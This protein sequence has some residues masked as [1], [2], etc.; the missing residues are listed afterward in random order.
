MTDETRPD[1]EALRALSEAA[2]PGPW[3]VP[4][5]STVTVCHETAGW[6]AKC[7]VSPDAAFIA[8]A[9][10]YVRAPL[11]AALAPTAETC[12]AEGSEWFGPLLACPEPGRDGFWSYQECPR[13][14]TG[15]AA[16]RRLGLVHRLRADDR[17]HA[18]E[19]VIHPA[20]STSH[21]KSVAVEDTTADLAPT[22]AGEGR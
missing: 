15:M 14:V 16:H 7:Y 22:E 20:I 6:I 1:R 12:E 21:H 8:A 18:C 13:G 17:R 19:D 2:T 9:A 5:S 4:E 10:N 3:T 11:A